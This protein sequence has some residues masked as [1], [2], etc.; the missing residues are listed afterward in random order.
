MHNKNKCYT[1]KICALLIL[2]IIMT[3]SRTIALAEDKKTSVW[4]V[5]KKKSESVIDSSINSL[6]LLIKDIG[7]IVEDQ[8]HL[9]I[10]S[11]W[12]P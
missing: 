8:M 6:D 10:V 1:S 7:K 2:I 4:E 5:I 9:E 12:M 11:R 3:F